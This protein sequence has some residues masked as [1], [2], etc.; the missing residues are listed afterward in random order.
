[1]GPEDCNDAH[2][3]DVGHTSE[4]EIGDVGDTNGVGNTRRD[5]TSGV[6][7]IDGVFIGCDDYG[8]IGVDDGVVACSDDPSVI[9]DDDRFLHVL[10]TLKVHL[11]MVR[12]P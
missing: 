8:A 6:G 12:V 2:D 3:D 10:R 4:D 9:G 5:D 1:M 11:M 7:D